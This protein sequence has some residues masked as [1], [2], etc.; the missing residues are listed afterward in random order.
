MKRLRDKGIICE[1]D[2]MNR[3]VKAQ[4]KEANKSGA[5]YVI[6]I[7]EDEIK[8]NRFKVKNMAESTDSDSTPDTILN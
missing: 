2:F 8:N 4:M 1:T 6:V 5:K 3:S 7:G